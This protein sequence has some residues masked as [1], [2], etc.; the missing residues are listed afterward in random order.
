MVRRRRNRNAVIEEDDSDDSD[1][2]DEAAKKRK[3]RE[4]FE[5]DED[6]YDLLE[7]NQVTGF[8]RRVKKK[9][10]KKASD[11]EKAKPKTTGDL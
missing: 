3:R 1:E 5:L 9:R 11:A 8:K 7:D 6:D 10:L 2:D 4:Q